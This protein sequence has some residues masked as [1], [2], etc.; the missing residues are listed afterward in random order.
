MQNV[1]Q[2]REELSLGLCTLQSVENSDPS[3]LPTKIRTRGERLRDLSQRENKRFVNSIEQQVRLGR[4]REYIRNRPPP[5]FRQ[6]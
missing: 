4:E 1:L 6:P 2:M 5:E 3:L